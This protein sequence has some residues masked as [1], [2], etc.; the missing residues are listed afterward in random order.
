M[1]WWRAV[2]CAMR[3]W[4]TGR[5]G[6]T[7][8]D[9]LVAGDPSSPGY[10]G[11]VA[12]LDV[13]KAPGSEE[14]LAGE[15][16]AVAGFT[17]AYRGAM[18]ASAPKRRRRAWVSL[19]A[20]GVVV[21]V[22]AGVAVL[23]AG[24]TALAAETGHL[25]AGVQQRV[26]RMFSSLGVPAPGT[27]VR[28]TGVGPAGVAG[29]VRPSTSGIPTPSPRAGGT[30][31]RP[32]DPATL[33]L[34]EAW[35]AERKDPHGKAMTAQAHRALFA[36]AGGQSRV[37]AFC[38]ALLTPTPDGRPSVGVAPTH[39]GAATA[40]PSHPGGQGTGNGNSSSHPTPGPHQQS[41]GT[42]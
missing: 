8:A 9:R 7:E 22:A 34:C 39:P 32:S 38:A 33:A 28:P 35:D 10:P 30:T 40:T 24:G 13:A 37:P 41:H 19:S 20:R 15:R 26:H 21:K 11:L 14:E 4:R 42:R 12:L 29:S 16:T 31:L 25:P 18:P 2:W 27:G 3:A 23:A 36:V 6:L 1:R 5:I 17:A